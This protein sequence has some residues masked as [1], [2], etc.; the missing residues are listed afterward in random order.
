[1]QN[2]TDFQIKKN[3][4]NLLAGFDMKCTKKDTKRFLKHFDCIRHIEFLSCVKV[5]LDIA[6]SDP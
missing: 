5:V 2:M 4:P 1:M 6:S 3:H